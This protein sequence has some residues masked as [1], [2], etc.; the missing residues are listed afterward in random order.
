MNPFSISDVIQ[1]EDGRRIIEINPL[2]D[3]YCSFDCVFCSL[4]RT[5][6]KSDDYIPMDSSE[7][8]K[9]LEKKLKEEKPDLVY[10]SPWG[11]GLVNPD[12]KRIIKAIKSSG[13]KVSLLSNGY[14]FMRPEYRETLMLC[15]ELTGE[16]AATNEKDFQKLQ[17]PKEGYTLEEYISNMENFR[18]DYKG[19]FI[20]DITVL[21]NYTDSPE[22]FL[23]YKKVMQRLKPDKMIIST[24]SSGK[25]G[26]AFGVEP[27][28]ISQLQGYLSW[29]L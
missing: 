20:L 9:D 17:R 26:E 23:V 18:K 15:D 14:A 22:A 19:F 10:I 6:V 2:P 25:Y 5:S 27:E 28:R 12:L 11:E 1:E 3:K 7:F 13:S 21:K 24:P 8:I 29:Q 4:G 16:I